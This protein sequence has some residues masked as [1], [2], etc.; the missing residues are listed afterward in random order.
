MKRI[1]ISMFFFL[2]A[3][4]AMGQYPI[5]SLKAEYEMKEHSKRIEESTGE[6]QESGKIY[7]YVLQLAPQISYF[8]DP[9]QYFIDSIL[10]D[11][12]GN[13]LYWQVTEM[14]MSEAK[15]NSGN[16]MEL[17]DKMGYKWGKICMDCRV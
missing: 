4:V 5:A 1:L 10:N 12:K 9:Q 6:I 3:I 8:Y 17:R 11:P 16:Y 15:R 2:L 7:T 14:A 13:E